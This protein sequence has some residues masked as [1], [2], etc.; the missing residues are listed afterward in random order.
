MFA[1]TDSP[2]A[3]AASTRAIACAFFGQFAAPAA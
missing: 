3:R 2:S 1:P